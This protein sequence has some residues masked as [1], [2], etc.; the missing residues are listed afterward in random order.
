[1]SP[2]LWPFGDSA[3]PLGGGERERE[4]GHYWVLEKQYL[5]LSD[6]CEEYE[7][8]LLVEEGGGGGGVGFLRECSC[9]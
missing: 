6:H 1:M 3:V 5:L 4:G 2:L 7:V 9:C 8:S